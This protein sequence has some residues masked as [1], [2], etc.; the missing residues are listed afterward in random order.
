MLKSLFYF[1]NYPLSINISLLLLRLV[2]GGFMLTHGAG[3]FLKLISD[4]PIA[5]H[6]PIGLGSEFSLVLTVFAE[7]FCA[8]FLMLGFA[9]RFA[10]IPLLITMFV[11]AFIVHA[12]DGFGKQELPLMYT[13]IYF[14]LAF[15]GAGKFSLDGVIQKMAK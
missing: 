1:A 13:T 15:A 5:F 3:K 9:T 14:F 8:V 2:G 7:V 4:K 11:A 10:A 12:N 6:D